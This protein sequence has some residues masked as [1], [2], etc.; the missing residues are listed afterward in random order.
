MKNAFRQ[1][2]THP[3]TATDPGMVPVNLLTSYM[4]PMCKSVFGVP[5]SEGDAVERGE[6]SPEFEVDDEQGDA[7]PLVN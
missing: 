7:S 4:C 2:V 3:A 5:E 1:I 6:G